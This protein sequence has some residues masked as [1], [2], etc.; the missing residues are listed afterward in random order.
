M[1]VRIYIPR[2]AAALALGA[3]RVARALSA[4]AH[5][6]KLDIV[7]VRNGSRGMHWLEPLVEVETASG[8]VASGPV[9]PSDIAGLVERRHPGQ[10]KSGRQMTVATDHDHI[11]L[12]ASAWS[13]S[14]PR[15]WPAMVGA[16][17]NTVA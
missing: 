17:A 7:I 16:F 9:K 11:P 1:T 15:W 4:E 10:E 13:N 6:R 8:R 3:D 12:L 14:S 2:D 5:S